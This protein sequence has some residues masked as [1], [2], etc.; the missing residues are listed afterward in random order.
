MEYNQH[1]IDY[2][3]GVIPEFRLD[4]GREETVARG[5]AVHL[6]KVP[7]IGEVVDRAS[8]PGGMDPGDGDEG[9]LCAGS[10]EAA[11]YVG[12]ISAGNATDDPHGWNLAALNCVRFFVHHSTCSIA[13]RRPSTT[14]ASSC[15]PSAPSTIR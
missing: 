1:G 2:P 4:A 5:P 15:A 13:S 7:V 6:T 3:K 8:R 10:S 9:P 14:L 11:S 12:N